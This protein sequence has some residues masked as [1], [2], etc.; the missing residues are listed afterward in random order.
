MIT[1]G[2]KDQVLRYLLKNHPLEHTAKV[3]LPD[4]L[5]KVKVDFA[6]LESVLSILADD[7]YVNLYSCTPDSLMLVISPAAHEFIFDSGGYSRKAMASEL[8]IRNMTLNV[9]YLEFQLNQLKREIE[10]IR[11]TLPEKA[12]RLLNFLANIATVLGVALKA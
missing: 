5:D 11:P 10:D 9:E 1:P 12:E 7:K 3:N 4:L 2:I 6:V 8:E